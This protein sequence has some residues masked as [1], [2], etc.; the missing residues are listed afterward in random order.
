MD[1]NNVKS[2]IFTSSVAIYGLNKENPDEG[3]PHD[4][5]TIMEKV[6]GRQKRYCVSGMRKLQKSVP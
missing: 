5:L 6:S 4:P 3:H 2:I 1:K